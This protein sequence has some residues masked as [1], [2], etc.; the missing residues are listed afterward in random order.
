[1]TE[2]VAL[3]TET[4]ARAPV[5]SPRVTKCEWTNDA[6]IQPVCSERELPQARTERIAAG[7][8]VRHSHDDVATILAEKGCDKSEVSAR[9]ADI[10]FQ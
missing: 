4:D 5:S 1:M 3:E 7:R 10:T 9:T 8:P 2:K 6:R